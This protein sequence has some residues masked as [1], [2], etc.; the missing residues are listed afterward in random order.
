MKIHY[1]PFFTSNAYVDYAKHSCGAEEAGGQ[2]LFNEKV[3]GDAELLR[4]LEL[5][6][7]VHC[8]EN[9]ATDRMLAY[10][11]PLKDYFAVAMK[12][13]SASS[14]ASSAATSERPKEELAKVFL[15]KEFKVDALA[16]ADETLK[17]RDALMMA[18]WNFKVPGGIDSPKLELLAKVEPEFVKD[19]ACIGSADRWRKI[20]ALAEGKRFMPEGTEIDV[21]WP[22]ELIEPIVAATFDGLEKNGCVVRYAE[23]GKVAEQENDL[24]TI[25][26]IVMEG[27]EKHCKL[28]GDGS[29]EV[30][31]SVSRRQAEEYVAAQKTDCWQLY[32][33]TSNKSFDN[34][35][36]LRHEPV[37]GSSAAN[38]LSYPEQLFSIGMGLFAYPRNVQT[39]LSWL[40]MPFCPVVS[41]LRYRLARVLSDK[42]GVGN[43]D[44]FDEISKYKDR[45]EK[46]AEEDGLVY[47]ADAI[48]ANLLQFIPDPTEKIDLMKIAGF[49]AALRKWAYGMSVIF[50]EKNEVLSDQFGQLVALTEGLDKLIAIN[51]GA[52]ISQDELKSWCQHLSMISDTKIYAACKG[53]RYVIE[54]PA[55][56]LD[57]PDSIVW[58][59]CFNEKGYN[60]RF[61]FLYDAEK[62]ALVK[63]G[64]R[65]MDPN[66]L[67]RLYYY[68]NLQPLF[69]AKKKLTII[70]S[71][72]DGGDITSENPLYSRIMECLRDGNKRYRPKEA[73]IDGSLMEEVE[74]VDNR[75]DGLKVM[76]DDDVVISSREIESQTSLFDL[77]QNP[78]DYVCKYD[79][80]FRKL[81][82]FDL[83][84]LFIIKGTTAHKIIEILFKDKD[85]KSIDNIDILKRKFDTSYD[86]IYEEVLP[87]YGALLQ[88]KEN[89][90][91]ASA[92]KASLK[93]CIEK[94]LYYIDINGLTPIGNEKKLQTELH[95][96]D[97]QT[98]KIDAIIDL[99]LKDQAGGYV[100]FDFKWTTGTKHED[101]LA[102]NSSIQLAIYAKAV[103]DTMPGAMVRTAYFKMPEGKLYSASDGFRDVEY[104][105]LGKNPIEGDL[106]ELIKNSYIYRMTELKKEHRIE[107]GE[108]KAFEIIGNYFNDTAE[109]KLMPLI[110]DKQS[111]KHKASNPYSDFT[112]LK[113]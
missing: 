43:E 87:K 70:G 10:Y 41:G 95:L 54:S 57:R 113:K 91:E 102:N 76:L 42:C 48:D 99:L 4:I 69:A 26:T 107:L 19:A 44:W 108:G 106:I 85:G 23:I 58:V 46:Q 16:V 64:C 81:N 18:G 12:S 7:G 104:V 93:K 25:R 15:L 78:F 28:K 105:R 40:T 62:K 29:I 94:L 98:L 39:L 111:P 97:G 90:L 67:A 72:K 31:H 3:C 79:A 1:S 30:L 34:L 80:R 83:D 92:F 59:D 5:Y 2:I 89:E 86:S 45:K 50:M 96:A 17:W 77:I 35:Q 101:S 53:S 36:N 60:D 13:L 8:E 74:A 51:G 103:N 11:K 112:T 109:K 49:N 100:I 38:T 47:D 14:V 73:E 75:G 37:S 63:D 33:N 110:P 21:R 68:S 52:E 20:E 55:D 56:I 24:Q 65:L 27:S 82:T 66:A 84:N 22:K 88:L 61:D 9:S 71:D 32:I 6:A